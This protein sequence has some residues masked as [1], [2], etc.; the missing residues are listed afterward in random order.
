MI[1]AKYYEKKDDSALQCRLCPH[2][3]VIAPGKAGICRVRKNDGGKLFSLSYEQVTSLNMDPIEKKPLY[4]FFPG[5]MILSAG[6]LGCNFRCQFC[7]NWEIS[8]GAPGDIPTRKLTSKAALQLAKENKS[9]GIAYTYNEPLVNFEWALETS[10]L[11]AAEGMKNVLVTNGYINQEP[12]KELLNSIDAANIDLK[13]FDEGFY[14]KMCGGKLEPVLKTIETMVKAGRHVELTT[15]IIPG[16]NDSPAEI[17]KLVSWVAAL[18]DRIPLHFSRYFPQYK[19]ETE[20]TSMKALLN[21]YE[22]ARKKLKYVYIGNVMEREY[23][24]THCP[25]CGEMVIERN[26]YDI[27]LRKFENGKCS[28]CGSCCDIVC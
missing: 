1:E 4:H 27:G 18:S 21:A 19:M 11:F 3:C 10:K 20:P 2:A 7:Q 22:I 12:L 15:L 24:N 5:S 23:G 13:S 6:T 17:E 25:S 14:R 9:I 16:A 28:K 26:G 8:Q